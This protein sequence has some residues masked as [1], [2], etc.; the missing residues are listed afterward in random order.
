MGKRDVLQYPDPHLR[1]PSAPVSQFDAA[2]Y[3]LVDDLTETFLAG[4]G[5]GLSAPQIG[6]ARQVVVIDESE[7][8]TETCVFINPRIVDRKGICL[9]EERCLSVPDFAGVVRRSPEITVVADDVHG[10]RAKH[11]LSGMTAVC[12]QH[13]IDHLNGTLFVDRLFWWRRLW[14]QHTTRRRR[15]SAHV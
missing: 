15:T 5:I 11:E 8:R 10:N 9:V 3:S 4:P 7:S 2:L 6:A 13:E 14:F 1:V 12:M